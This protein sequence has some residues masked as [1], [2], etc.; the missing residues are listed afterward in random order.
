MKNLYYI[1]LIIIISYPALS[2][3]STDS[4]AG[5][6]CTLSF[7][8]SANEM[9]RQAEIFELYTQSDFGYPQFGLGFGAGYF[10][11]LLS[12]NLLAGPELSYVFY[13]DSTYCCTEFAGLFN[14]SVSFIYFLKSPGEGIYL[15]YGIGRYN[16]N[17]S[18]ASLQQ[19]KK[20]NIWGYSESFSVGYTTRRGKAIFIEISYN[21]NKSNRLGISSI[22]FSAGVHL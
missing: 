2:A 14:T 11:R 6:F 16:N 4:E 8:V 5:T 9:V 17:F 15:K 21:R 18:K 22:I 3:D 1:I 20:V 7:R 19:E 12:S 13:S 10:F